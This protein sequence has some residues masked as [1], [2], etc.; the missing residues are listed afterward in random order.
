MLRQV[1]LSA[2]GSDRLRSVAERAPV[3]RSVV[4]RFVPGADLPSALSTVA[5]LSAAGLVVSLDRLGEDVRDPAD[6]AETVS[7][8]RLLFS[9]LADAGLATSAEASV[10]LTAVGLGL[11]DGEQRALDNAREIAGVARDAGTTIT[12]DMEDH[13]LTDRTLAA[14]R[15]LRV[16]FPD[17]GAVVQAYL[18]RTEADCRDL[19]VP[20][21]RVRL[22]KGAYD[23]PVD[24]AFSSRAEVDASYVRCLGAL[25]AG[26]GRPLVA[27]HDPRL[28]AIADALAVRHGRRPA[29]WEYQMLY[30]IR[31]DEQRRLAAEGHTM[32]VYL[33]YGTQWWGYFMRR[34]AERP[35]NVG[36]F[37]RALASRG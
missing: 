26:G 36:F 37:L 17:V 16:D 19:A 27:T 6:A 4:H 28:I 18:R 21:S 5:E 34:L 8:Y 1:V 3:A 33:P 7:A 31:P 12:V 22:C 25:F 15:A 30:G 24:V 35:A 10:K 29:D 23:E 13:T 2:A 9:R 20:G 32:R 14:V 11:P